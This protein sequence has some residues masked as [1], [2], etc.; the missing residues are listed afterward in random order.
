MIAKVI[1]TE[2]DYR[3]ALKRI[4]TIF[5]AKIGTAQGDELELLSTLV[6]LYEQKQFPID[7]PDPVAAI[8]FRMEQQGLQAKDLVRYLGSPSRVSEVLGR[9]RGLSVTMMRNLVNGLGIPSD[10]FLSA[11]AVARTGT[12]SKRTKLGVRVGRPAKAKA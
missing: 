5:D 3:A 10:V 8:Q 11:S 6:E 2:A 12:R 7:A 4:E 9:R 1:K